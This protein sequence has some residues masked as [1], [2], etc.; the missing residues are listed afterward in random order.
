M[1]L[2]KMT[3]LEYIHSESY[4]DEC[5]NTVQITSVNRVNSTRQA[6]ESCV[7]WQPVKFSTKSIIFLG[8]FD[9]I[10]IFCCSKNEYV[11]GW[12]GVKVRAK[13]TSPCFWH[14]WRRSVSAMPSGKKSPWKL[15]AIP[16]LRNLRF[17]DV[18]T[19]TL[20]LRNPYVHQYKTTLVVNK[21]RKPSVHKDVLQCF[22][23]GR[24]IG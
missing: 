3:T 23:S 4:L 18:A 11:S 20:E 19:A 22:W 2:E 13:T 5:I 1:S 10:N 14:S 12:L 15:Q 21:A 6:I 16:R 24:Y 9:P 17:S 7:T 8:Y